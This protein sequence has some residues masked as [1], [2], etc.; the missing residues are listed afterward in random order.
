MP[1]DLTGT[2]RVVVETSEVPEIKILER[3]Y[4]QVLDDASRVVFR[5]E[6]DV[7]ARRFVILPSEVWVARRYIDDV[8]AA[9][10]DI[11]TLITRP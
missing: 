2:T 1:V 8:R 6:V 5:A 3:V 11:R 4:A 10:T 9:L 7:A